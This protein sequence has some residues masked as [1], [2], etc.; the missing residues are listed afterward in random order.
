MRNLAI[1]I[2]IVVAVLLVLY[3]LFGAGTFV[4]LRG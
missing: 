1:A 2:V 4:T 3:L